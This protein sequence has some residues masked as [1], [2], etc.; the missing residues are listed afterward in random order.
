MTLNTIEALSAILYT[1]GED[2]IDEAQLLETLAIDSETL[3]T[4]I[5]QLNI[6]GLEIHQYGK[7]FVLTTQREAEPYIESLI[8]NKASTKLSQ[9]AMEVLAIIA[10][11]QPVTRNDIE[12]IRGVSSDGPVKTLIGKGL[13][14]P[15][16]NPEARGQQLYT[17]ELFLNVFGLENLE[18]LPTTDEEEE[19][20]ESFFSQ[21]VNQKGES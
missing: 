18:A 9:A 14:E 6:P 10:Y 5:S 15:R 7:R 19:E 8:I 4:T 16:N 12:L 17:T 21:L 2:G 3:N 20:I 1:V 13:I 11:N